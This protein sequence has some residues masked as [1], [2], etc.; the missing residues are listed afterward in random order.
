VSSLDEAV[1][2]AVGGGWARLPWSL[3]GA[4]GEAVLA[5]SSVTVRCLVRPDGSLPATGEEDDVVAIVARS[6]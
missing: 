5:Q 2:A 3:V 1:E 4:E 6:Y